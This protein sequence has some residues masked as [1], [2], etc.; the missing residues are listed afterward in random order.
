MRHG[1]R[2]CCGWVRLTGV[3]L[4]A[5]CVFAPSLEAQQRKKMSGP[6]GVVFA[7]SDGQGRVQ[8]LWLAHVDHWPAAWRLEE[9]PSGRLLAERI[10]P[11]DAA[12]LERLAARERESV[13]KISELLAPTTPA[14]KK[15]NGLG[16]VVVRA[17]TDWDYARAAGLAWTLENVPPGAR[18]Y[19]V[20]G[21][22][23]DGKPTRLALQTDAVDSS[24]ATPL[25]PAPASLRAE[26]N[27]GGAALFWSPA[28]ASPKF[29][30]VA[31]QVER[32]AA[33]QAQ[34]VTPRPLVLGARWEAEAPALVDREAPVEQE[35]TYEVSSV[36]VLG[37][38]SA[39]ASVT[40]FVPDLDALV[41][42]SP[43]TAQAAAG[44][45]E[46][47][48]TPRKNPHT[49]GYVVERAYLSNGPYE[50]LTAQ[51]L[52]PSAESYQ[53]S[54]L[55]GGTTYYYRVRAVGPRGDVG[56]PSPAAKAQPANPQKPPH[57]QGLKADAGRT[58]VRL[59]WQP[60]EFG[61]AGYFVERRADKV[62]AWVRLNE[63]VSPEPLYDDYFGLGTS[64]SF[65]YR[66]VAVAFDNEE[67][68]PS[69]TVEVTVADTQPPPVPSLTSV[70]GSGG[71]V[72][73]EF[74]P[75]LP[76]TATEQ[77]L[78]LRGGSAGD[79]GVVIGEPLPAGARRFQDTHVQ[80][81]YD[82]WYRLVAVDKAGNRSAPTGGVVVR[83]G[84]PSLPR[85]AR[86]QVEFAAK[87][88]PH[89]KLQ[90]AAPPAGLTV[91]VQRR[92]E[93]EKA[94]LT[95]TGAT[96]GTEALDA[97]PPRQGKTYYRILYQ[98]ANESQGA[99]SEAAEISPPLEQ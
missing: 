84:N 87:P 96:T 61:V 38:R 11:G 19:R 92:R 63:R 39:S 75:G 24:V 43:V 13:L 53:D 44:K 9:A 97:N 28:P 1:H 26:A 41:P 73:L 99:A 93:A 71:V 58:R 46:V 67:S 57:P 30:V 78:V 2:K 21:L 23:A 95:L 56:P 34:A 54:G 69:S 74:A 40:L 66:V 51:A 8:L 32:Q 65:Q 22:D 33:G 94:W 70:D 50:A 42:P 3:L 31:Y 68:E 6:P 29:P 86:P 15:K 90:F 12:A 4:L 79:L 37:R 49:T 25:P 16:F 81:G 5:A 88:F 62:A 27:E 91:V 85:P 14:Q 82:Y 60:V 48:W 10:Q 83:V 45:V 89:V 59:T 47:R 18:R 20:V 7:A 80:P 77:F 36:D 72:T 35:I 98:A 76:E 52:P 55:R 17:M 64:G